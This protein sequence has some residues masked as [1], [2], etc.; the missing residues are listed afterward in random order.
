MNTF[1]ETLAQI[2]KEKKDC[3]FVS[4]HLDD[5][6]LSAGGLI[7][8]LSKKV[9]VTVV[10]VFTEC[11]TTNSFSAKAFLKQ[12]GYSA[13]KLF[14]LR[15][16]EDIAAFKSVNVKTIHLGYKDALWRKKK[17]IN[18]INKFLQKIL[19]EF[20]LIYPTY[21]FHISKGE[22]AKEDTIT[23]EE[24]AQDLQEIIKSQKNAVVFCPTGVGK[25]IDHLVTKQ[26]VE[27]IAKPIY[28]V[29]QPYAERESFRT[30]D[31]F[32][33]NVNSN[34][35]NKLVSYYKSQILPLF[36]RLDIPVLHEYFS[37]IHIVSSTILPKKIGSYKLI[38][39]IN[40]NKNHNQYYF[41]VYE[42]GNRKAF[43][44]VWYGNIKDRSYYLLK[45]SINVFTDIESAYK[46]HPELKT[47]FLD[48]SF[49]EHITSLETNNT[50]TLL[51]EFVEEQ[52][53]DILSDEK[54]VQLVL[55]VLNY[56]ETIYKNMDQQNLKTMKRPAL[57]WLL[58][59][60]L[61][62]ACAIVKKPRLT[63][64]IIKGMFFYWSSLFTIVTDR[65]EALV[66]RDLAQW[67]IFM[68]KQNKIY[69]HDLQ[70]TCITHPL[71]EKVILCLKLWHN[72]SLSQKMFYALQSKYFS[73]EK[74]M[75]IFRAYSA[76]FSIYSL[77]ASIG[78]YKKAT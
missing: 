51:M 70:L 10:T 33:F 43:A 45:N 19:P 50:L 34:T 30:K 64:K 8:Y 57:Y 75:R 76:F 56:L 77:F 47:T 16:Q 72:K 58:I 63:V 18:I 35:K 68:N 3:I 67:N 14:M 42:N 55:R 22:I 61:I 2:V 26:A 37:H 6:A 49:P 12:C 44:K 52:K 74:D 65:S 40:P 13:K 7:E 54:L 24:I 59:S 20:G 41:G 15:K 29:D 62:T 28:W 31:F 71:I 23:I 25:H 78:E 21:R 48:I 66:H 11:G 69:I 27:L 39:I 9:N 46:K 53:I 4:P 17:K 60:P 1:E 36:G 5:A 32:E 73:T 38:Q